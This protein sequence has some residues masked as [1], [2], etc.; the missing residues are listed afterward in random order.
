MFLFAAKYQKLSR[1]TSALVYALIFVNAGWDEVGETLQ[2]GS[3]C[4]S[5]YLRCSRSIREPSIQRLNNTG[6]VP[7]GFY[8]RSSS[9]Y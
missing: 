4:D 2:T 8:F 3:L 1:M 5:L 6:S 9:F 7:H